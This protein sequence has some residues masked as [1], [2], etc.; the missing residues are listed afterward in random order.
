MARV[1]S[2]ARPKPTS[3]GAKALSASGRAP[4]ASR[5]AGLCL[6]ASRALKNAP[7]GEAMARSTAPPTLVATVMARAD[8]ANVHSAE[9]C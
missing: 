7:V 4:S 5:P 9:P 2:A 1:S 3:P 8:E 6:P